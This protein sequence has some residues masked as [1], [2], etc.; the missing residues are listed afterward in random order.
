MFENKSKKF[1]YGVSLPAFGFLVLTVILDEY[2]RVNSPLVPN[3]ENGYI[4]PMNYHGTVVYLNQTEHL[5]MY[6]LPS[7]AF[8][9]VVCSALLTSSRINL[10]SSKSDQ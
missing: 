7:S 4:Y 10:F 1:R 2:C 9:I 8:L 6:I 3:A 5:L